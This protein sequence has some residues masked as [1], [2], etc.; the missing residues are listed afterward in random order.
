VIDL[1][2]VVRAD[3]AIGAWKAN[4][5]HT[6]TDLRSTGCLTLMRLRTILVV[7]RSWS[8]DRSNIVTSG[9][10]QREGPE[11]QAPRAHG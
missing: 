11:G 3:L 2:A 9:R 1:R 7:V 10:S 6:S 8:L 4:R 5:S